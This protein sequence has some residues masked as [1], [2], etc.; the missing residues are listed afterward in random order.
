[1]VQKSNVF[2]SKIK[3]TGYWNYT[4]LY[5]FCFD[6]LKD[7]NYHVKEKAYTEKLS[8]F[9]KE[10]IIEWDAMKK[11]TDYY[12]NTISIKWHILGMKDAEV[13]RDGKKESTNKGE[14]AIEIKADLVTDYENKWESRV[15][16][17]FLRGIYDKYI[18]RTT[19]EE[20]EDRLEDDA[21]EFADQTKAFLEIKGR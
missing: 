17:K 6:W 3:Q 12:K 2:K 4:D 7:N 19:T 18:V 8:S 13:E 20:Y 9:G 5:N 16:W 15:F 10:I 21:T 14:V 11:V 1:M